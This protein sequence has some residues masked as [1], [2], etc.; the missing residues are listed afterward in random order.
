MK[1][2]PSPRWPDGRTRKATKTR[3]AGHE[4]VE[5]FV[6][7]TEGAAR[8]RVRRRRL[9]CLFVLAPQGEPNPK[10]QCFQCPA[11]G[12]FQ[13]IQWQNP[14][15][16]QGRFLP[17]NTQK[18][19]TADTEGRVPGAGCS[20]SRAGWLNGFGTEPGRAVST[21]PPPSPRWPYGRTRKNTKARF[22]GHERLRATK[23]AARFRVRRRRLLCLFVLAP[24]GRSIVDARIVL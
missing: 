12:G 13:C 11:A 21:K 20:D 23:G 7:A 19:P 18:R 4:S 24:Q 9:L 6:R 14:S 16:R 3:F 1:P 8:F 22:A 17:Q 15:A 2:P 5:G 10:L